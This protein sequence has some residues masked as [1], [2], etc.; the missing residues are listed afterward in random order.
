M[1]R[2]F[3]SFNYLA[4]FRLILMSFLISL[5]FPSSHLSSLYFCL[6]SYPSFFSSF[7]SSPSILL[8]NALSSYYFCL[9]LPSPFPF[10]SPLLPLSSLLFS[11]PS[12]PLLFSAFTSSS[13]LSLPFS[14]LC[15]PFHLS[16]VPLDAKYMPDVESCFTCDPLTDHKL[17]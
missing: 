13:V 10:S 4:L 8:Y 14:S 1:F 2:F 5:S 12:P 3:F 16:S 17:V 11:L 6:F 7:L 15:S 9:F